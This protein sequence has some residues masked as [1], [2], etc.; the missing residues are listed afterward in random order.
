MAR[1]GILVNL[2]DD[3]QHWRY[4]VS[5]VVATFMNLRFVKPINLN[6]QMLSFINPVEQASNLMSFQGRIISGYCCGYGHQ[7]KSWFKRVDSG[8]WFGDSYRI[9]LFDWGFDDLSLTKD[10]VRFQKSRTTPVLEYTSG[11]RYYVVRFPCTS[12]RVRCQPCS[13]VEFIKKAIAKY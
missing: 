7:Q 12:R 13:L 10:R 11:E 5:P 3:L 4:Y 2:Y 1:P 6:R 8:F 9:W